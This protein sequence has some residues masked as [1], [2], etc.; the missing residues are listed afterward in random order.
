MGRVEFWKGT[1]V[2]LIG[3]STLFPPSS[4]DDGPRNKLI[5]QSRYFSD[6]V[7]MARLSRDR[8]RETDNSFEDII[9]ILIDVVMA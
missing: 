5:G 7:A 4:P 9:G 8:C 1:F 2:R 6:L 3:L